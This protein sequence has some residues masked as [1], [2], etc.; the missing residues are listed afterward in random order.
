MLWETLYLFWSV[1]PTHQSFTDILL[2]SQF[3][4]CTIQLSARTVSLQLSPVKEFLEQPNSRVPLYSC[5]D[6]EL[7]IQWMYNMNGYKMRGR[8]PVSVFTGVNPEVDVE[9]ERPHQWSQ[10]NGASESNNTQNLRLQ[11]LLVNIV[12]YIYTKVQQGRTRTE[13][14]SYLTL[15]LSR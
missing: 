3:S 11:L 2:V 10:C 7:H 1:F 4:N 14:R 13:S 5:V 6:T 9:L 8:N 15:H 12:G